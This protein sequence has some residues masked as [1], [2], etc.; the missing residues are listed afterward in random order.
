MGGDERGE[1]RDWRRIMKRGN[2]EIWILGN[3]KILVEKK[4]KNKMGIGEKRW[5]EWKPFL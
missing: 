3:E 2:G 1:E 4:M 5:R